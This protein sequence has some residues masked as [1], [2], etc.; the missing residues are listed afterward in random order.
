MKIAFIDCLS[1]I[2]GDM[3]LGALIDCGV[4]L[5]HI[6]E[7]ISHLG[8]SDYKIKTRKVIKNHIEAT[9][10]DIEFNQDKQP[11]RKYPAIVQMINESR[12]KLSIKQRAL[13]AFHCLG[14]AE[15]RIH[16]RKI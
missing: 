15:A 2:S 11:D 16:G 1:G 14:E 13:E 7:E 12:L 8:L 5:Q 4:P 6:E 10:V 3:T 9:K